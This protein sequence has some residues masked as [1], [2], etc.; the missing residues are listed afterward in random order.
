M[1]FLA[2]W[3]WRRRVLNGPTPFLHFRDY[4]PFEKDQALYFYNLE[5]PLPKGDL[6]QV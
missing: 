5:I 4:F 1:T 6:C 2:Y 3:F